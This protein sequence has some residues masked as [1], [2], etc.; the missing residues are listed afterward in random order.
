MYNEIGDIMKIIIAPAKQM[1]MK[2]VDIETTQPLFLKKQKQ[3]HTQLKQYSEEQLH[4]MMK[5]SF[6]MAKEVYAYYHQVHP[7]CPA[8]YFY[9]G[10]VYKQLKLNTYQDKEHAYLLKH[11][12]ILSAYYGALRY[13]DAISNY[14][15]DMKM[16]VSDISLYEFWKKDIQAYFEKEDMIIS[17]ASKEFTSMV[18]HPN[19]IEID[20]VEQKGEKLVR[21]AMLVK[22]ARG[23]MLHIMIKEQIETIA[24]LQAI[25]FDGY[26]Y[27]EDLSTASTFVFYRGVQREY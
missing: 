16:K 23:K 20:F 26:C 1:K 25:T 10:T 6:K 11:I 5:I 7:S 4:D 13:N 27:R 14:R 15:L 9:S 19:I 2:E 17:L 12:V 8:L 3:L 22:Q 24:K 18:K 21:N